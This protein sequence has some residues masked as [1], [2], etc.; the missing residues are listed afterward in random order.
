VR[1]WGRVHFKGVFHVEHYADLHKVFHVEHFV[2]I[3]LH[4]Q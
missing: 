4:V 1:V 3:V 2:G